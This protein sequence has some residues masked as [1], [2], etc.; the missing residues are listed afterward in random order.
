MNHSGTSLS[1][2]IRRAWIERRIQATGTFRIDEGVKALEASRA[3]IS[4][5]LIGIQEANPKAITYDLRAKIYRWTPGSKLKTK[6]PACIST[7]NLE[8]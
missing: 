1:A 8:A 2:Q 7:F 6:I 3:Q 5:D 4:S